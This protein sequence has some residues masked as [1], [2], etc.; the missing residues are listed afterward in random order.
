MP[1][2]R[3]QPTP[4]PSPIEPARN[5]VRGAAFHLSD[6]DIREFQQLVHESAGSWLERDVAWQRASQLI[7]LIRLLAEPLP[8]ESGSI[9]ERV[10]TS[11]RLPESL[12][13]TKLKT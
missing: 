3:F 13:D 10:R 12:V 7:G 6:E 5:E 8:N 11:S 1:E 2:T 4:S 9:S